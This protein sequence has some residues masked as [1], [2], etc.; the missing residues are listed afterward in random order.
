MKNLGGVKILFDAFFCFG[1][2]LFL[3]LW[4]IAFEK[5]PKTVD[6]FREKFARVA[7]GHV[8]S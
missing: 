6:L 8:Y 5:M 2:K 1:R 7:D 3:V 4:P